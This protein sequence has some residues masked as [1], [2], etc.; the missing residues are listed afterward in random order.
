MNSYWEQ[1][2]FLKKADLAVI[3][4]GIV[5]IN[6]ALRYRELHPN[7][8]IVILERG[9]LPTGA[10]TRNA[11]FA[12]FGS[13]T[14][15]LDDLQSHSESEVWDLVQERWEGLQRM[16]AK[17]TPSQIGYVRHGGY[18][19]FRPEEETSFQ[20]CKAQLAYFNAK[21]ETITGWQGAFSVVDAYLDQVGFQGVQHLIRSRV[22]G[23]LHPARM[24]QAFYQKAIKT[25]IQVLNGFEVKE[26]QDQGKQVEIIA[27]NG[28][29]L[30]TSCALVATNGFARQLL[31]VNVQA[32]RNQVL[33]TKPIAELKVKGCFHYDKGYVYFRNVGNRILLGGGRNLAPKA[34]QTDEFGNTPLIQN[35]LKDILQTIILPGQKV[36]I[37][38]WWSGILGVGTQKKPIVQMH[39]KRVGVA[40]RM[41]GMGVAIGTS[42]GER[43]AEMIN[44][45]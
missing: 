45:S 37:E 13:P 40:V 19:I 44:E 29:R 25:G 39:T 8:H 10:S 16:Q 14:E 30:S 35:A 34:E 31:A 4:S 24:M 5:G 28:I 12:C 23:Q 11:G 43:A 33:I 22:E 20:A 26:I 7:A 1:D 17:L 41:G 38:R 9:T 3:G 2:T 42:I 27:T 18:E 21:F 32:A 15:L 36:E 6:A